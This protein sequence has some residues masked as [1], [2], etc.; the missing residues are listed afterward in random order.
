[1]MAVIKAVRGMTTLGLKEAKTLVE[2]AGG[3]VREAVSKDDAEEAKKVLE[4]AG[5][6]V[7]LK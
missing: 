4:A 7:E 3:V 1:K 6:K 5:A 2:T